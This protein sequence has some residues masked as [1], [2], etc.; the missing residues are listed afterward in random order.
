MCVCMCVCEMVPTWKTKKRK[1]SKFVKAVGYNRNERAGNW[2]LGMGRQRKKGE[3]ENKFT[4]GT[5]R[6]EN[7]KTLYVNTIYSSYMEGLNNHPPP[8]S[9]SH[10]SPRSYTVKINKIFH[11][12]PRLTTV[13]RVHQ[14]NICAKESNTTIHFK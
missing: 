7:I 13:P 5:E 2:R 9:T 3:K 8:H 1:T 6:C 10:I 4:L 12:L 14:N 11:L